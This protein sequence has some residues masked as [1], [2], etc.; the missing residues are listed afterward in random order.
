M[1][2]KPL[3]SALLHY[4]GLAGILLLGAILRFWQLDLKPLWPDEIITALF[5]L[6]HSYLDVPLNEVFPLSRLPQILTLQPAASCPQIAQTIAS[7]S[8][9]PPLFFCLMH[10]W[11][12]WLNLGAGSLA[13]EV[14]TLPALIGVGAIAA[15][16]DLSRVAFS[17]AAGLMAAAVMAVSPFA[18]YL[19]QEARHY[20]LPMLL[21]ILALS[22]LTRVLQAQSPQHTSRPGYRP[23]AH[24]LTWLG[25]MVVNSVGFYV[26]YFFLLAFVAQVVTLLGLMWQAPQTPPRTWM[27][28]G[29]AITAIVLSYLPWLPTLVSHFGRPET[30]WLTLS[31][32]RWSDSI[33]PLYQLLAGWVIMAIA[34]PV[35]NQPLWLTIPAGLVMIAFSG[36]LV[37]Q[38]LPGIKQLWRNSQ[39]HLPTLTL[40]SFTV[41]VLLQFF[42]LVY[43]FGKD[44]TIAPRYNFTYYPSICALLGAALVSIPSP[45]Y[46]RLKTGWGRLRGSPRRVQASVVLVGILSCLFVVNDLAFQKPFAPRQVAKD[47]SQEPLPLAVMVG[48]DSYQDVALGLSYAVELHNQHL[49]RQSSAKVA[50][51]FFKQSRGS[52]PWTLPSLAQSFTRELPL[53]LWVISPQHQQSDYPQR[54]TLSDQSSISRTQTC[55]LA[56]NQYHQAFGVPYQLYHCQPKL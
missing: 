16:Y 18:V 23:S 9:H 53:N 1:S 47:I 29:L 35:E 28:A 2:A 24:W 52:Q 22:G 6:G 34:L 50:V 54:L 48:Y 26:H 21:V 40:L 19:S 25:W 41:C 10:G 17:P 8:V 5:S 37:R 44:I 7:E 20:T 27:A 55:T 43:I 42:V 15:T 12:G 38:I 32:N 56:F 49:G 51:A 14:R 36:W 46:R 3:N 45:F 30:E 11:L 4:L 33:A 39:T 31:S 13:W